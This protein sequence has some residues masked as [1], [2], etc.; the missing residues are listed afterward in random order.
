[1]TLDQELLQTPQGELFP[2]LGANAGIALQTRYLM[3]LPSKYAPLLLSSKGYF[4]KEAY[5]I[6]K[7]AFQADEF[8]GDAEPILHWLRVSMHSTRV[9]HRRPPVTSLA[10][11]STFADDDLLD[12]R[13][14]ILNLMLPGRHAPAVG[15]E[16][17]I[18]QMASAVA[19]QA[20]EVRTS[21]IA[22]EVEREA[23]VTPSTKFGFLME[24]LKIYLN[25]QEEDQLPEFWFQ[26]AAAK[27]RQ[28]FSVIRE[29]LEHFSR[30]EHAFIPL[31]PVPEP[32]LHSDLATVTFLADSPDDLKTGL[33]P[34]VVMDG[35]EEYRA[36]A[37]ELSRNF[38]LMYERDYGIT[39]ADLE[40][41]KMPKDLRSFPLSFFDLERNLGLFGNLISAIL[42]TQHPITTQYRTFWNAL[43]RQ[44]RLQV[45]QEIDVTRYIKPVHILRNIQLICVQWF[46]SARARVPP[47]TPNFLEIWQRIALG[48]YTTP[49]LPPN[50]YHLVNPRNPTKPLP[51]SSGTAVTEITDDASLANSAISGLTGATGLTGVSG[52]RS[53]SMI[54][55]PNSDSHLLSLIPFNK[56][57]K[58]IIG[59]SQPPLTD[60]QE[61]IC[62]SYHV[63]G[64]CYSNCRRKKNHSH[65]LTLA[66]KERLENYI[67]DR[68]EKTP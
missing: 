17:A 6:L 1:V 52:G 55:N 21:R 49:K 34:F 9:N 24:S 16:A 2:T 66:E 41:F 50:L 19:H 27:K 12:H 68:L 56:K 35:S 4:V 23:P 33:Q 60:K 46:A 48:T 63:K 31:A 29:F 8:L 14:P 5:E 25:V 15:L 43:N 38:G 18:V 61:P 36:S 45:Q 42:G 47:M 64:A 65:A 59:T 53:S 7:A 26:F 30:S 57:L 22:R 58:E 37:L 39:F 44:Y 20:A 28:E 40:H 13:A 54:V 11:S 3:Y 62:L 32:K 10:L 51:S 67:A